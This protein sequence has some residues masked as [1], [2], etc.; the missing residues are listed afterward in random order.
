MPVFDGEPHLRA[1]IQSLLAQTYTNFELIILNDGSCDGS[2]AIIRE[3]AET[4]PR[5]KYVESI[6]NKGLIATLN[7]GLSLAKGQFIARA[8]QDDICMPVRFERQLEFLEKNQ[9]VDICSAW[10]KFIGEKTGKIELPEKDDAIRIFFL[11]NCAICHPLMFAR[12]SVFKKTGLLYNPAAFASEDYDLWTRLAAFA[13]FGNIPEVLLNYRIT[14]GQMSSK[15]FDAQQKNSTRCKTRMLN[16]VYNAKDKREEKVL[17]TIAN[18][19]SVEKMTQLKE[20]MI[21]LT[22]IGQANETQR[23][24]DIKLFQNY[25]LEK[26]KNL[27]LYYYHNIKRYRIKHLFELFMAPPEIRK[28]MSFTDQLKVV[29]KSLVFF[30]NKLA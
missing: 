20:S 1:A 29:L 4:D 24:F 12:H 19:K 2:E 15:Y 23:F 27:V 26:R 22:A 25:I 30:K 10:F 21:L 7:E 6:G 16:Y 3:F 5:I 13:K 9:D 8:D 28:Q 17:E 11:D 14:A 18:H